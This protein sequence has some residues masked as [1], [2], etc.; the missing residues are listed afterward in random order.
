VALCDRQPLRRGSLN[1]SPE[2]RGL[3]LLTG[4]TGYVGG[5]LL[6]ELERA[7]DRV[8]CLARRPERLA[9][10][11]GAQ[12]EVVRGDVLDRSSLGPALGGVETA[13][14][15]V[16]SLEAGP[17]FAARDLE[18]ARNFGQAARIAGVRKIVYL[19]G[20]GTGGPS[21]GEPLSEHLRSR[22]ET[23][24]ALRESAVPVIEFRA[25]VV[26][27]AGSLS[28]EMIRALVERLP[29]MV[30]P[31]WVTVATQPIGIED[32]VAYLLAARDAPF[33]DNRIYE[34]GGPDRVSYGDLMREYARQRGLSRT[35][36]RVPVLTPQLSS[37][38]LGLV[39]PVQARVGRKLIAGVR[40]PTV[41]T[42]DAALRD[43]P[44]RP[45]GVREAVARALAEEAS[46]AA[47]ARRSG[48]LQILEREQTIPASAREVFAF[49]SDPGNLARLTPPGLRFRIVGPPERQ[50]SAGS[51]LEYRIRWTFLRLKWVT[52][53]TR[54]EPEVEFEDVQEEG[55]YRVWIHTHRFEPAAGGVVMRDR[56]EYELPFGTLGRPAH[57]VLVRRQLEEIFDF[58]RRAIEEIFR[59][60]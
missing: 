11:H 6:R 13:Y 41:V 24:N 44:I 5:R 1:R 19:G 9:S 34:I 37:L 57:R 47:R 42:D 35:F 31:R 49:F 59:A 51:R 17:D 58:R 38:W 52:R 26:I 46:R 22:Q 25:S 48:G 16:H 28:F 55:P 8:R 36:L 29:V 32:V 33:G 21:G 56:V 53:I 39:T 12:T 10:A 20:L 30:W 40:N 50:L 14:Y 27:G 54:W 43:F 23:G 2:S 60:R 15:L 3:V 4:A 18:A 7:G 45:R